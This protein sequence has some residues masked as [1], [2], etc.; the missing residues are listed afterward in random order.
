MHEH[1][2]GSPPVSKH[3]HTALT[4]PKREL[5]CCC[6]QLASE[7]RMAILL[8]LKVSFSAESELVCLY[9]CGRGNG[10]FGGDEW[11]C[12]C[13]VAS[14]YRTPVHRYLVIRGICIAYPSASLSCVTWQHVQPRRFGHCSLEAIAFDKTVYRSSQELSL[15]AKARLR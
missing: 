4:M 3:Q 2:A 13:H 14:I 1:P 9:E 10:C 6:R 12:L 5:S 11:T 8:V 7:C 15:L